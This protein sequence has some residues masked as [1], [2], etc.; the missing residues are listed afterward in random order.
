[1]NLLD[2]LKSSLETVGSGTS[3]MEARGKNYII[4]DGIFRSISKAIGLLLRL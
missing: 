2:L 4:V 1:M 3:G